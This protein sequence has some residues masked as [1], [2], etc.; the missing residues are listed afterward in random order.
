MTDPAGR[1]CHYCGITATDLAPNELR[2]YGPGGSDVC[3]PCMKADPARE[4]AAA[5]VYR[6]LL[7][8]AAAASP[9]TAAEVGTPDG[10]RPFN[11]GTTP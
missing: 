10:P 3:Y 7:E 6:T 4:T 9:T 11:P 5:A 1:S 2:P 8:A